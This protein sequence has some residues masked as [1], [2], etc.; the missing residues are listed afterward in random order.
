MKTSTL[1]G[2]TAGAALVGAGGYLLYRQYHGP[3]TT[4]LS[5]VSGCGGTINEGIPVTIVPGYSGTEVASAIAGPSVG[6]RG[7]NEYPCLWAVAPKTLPTSY[8]G[9]PAITRRCGQV[10]VVIATNLS[11][12]GTYNGQP[13]ASQ[14]PWTGIAEYDDNVLVRV[15][16][17]QGQGTLGAWSGGFTC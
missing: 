14:G 15:Y 16:P 13:A 6:P 11:V 9:G 2:L 4:A 3:I 10:W 12:S 17:Q 1:V 5:Q 8:Q 7:E